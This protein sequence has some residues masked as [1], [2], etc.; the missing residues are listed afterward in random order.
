MDNIEQDVKD[1][2][3][4]GDQQGGQNSGMDKT[5]DQGMRNWNRASNSPHHILFLFSF[6][7]PSCVTAPQCTLPVHT[8][9]VWNQNSGE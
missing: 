9:P 1:V 2:S 7:P 5:I 8:Y 4:G 3:G 6:P